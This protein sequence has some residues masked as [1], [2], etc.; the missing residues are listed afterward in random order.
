M[1][2]SKI[3]ITNY[4]RILQRP[5]FTRVDD[6]SKSIDI[7]CGYDVKLDNHQVTLNI[8]RDNLALNE[9]GF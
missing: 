7:I 5:S 9:A 1:Q 3:L 8:A 2:E 6:E 4:P